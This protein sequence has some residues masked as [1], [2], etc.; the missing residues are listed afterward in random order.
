[1]GAG[2]YPDFQRSY[3]DRLQR[4]DSTF[5]LVEA[6]PDADAVYAGQAQVLMVFR[7][8]AR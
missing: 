6:F 7:R 5:E 8:R 1:M 4:P 3:A 2:N